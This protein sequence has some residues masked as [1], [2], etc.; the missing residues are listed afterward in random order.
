MIS[1]LFVF[2]LFFA[3]YAFFSPLSLLNSDRAIP[4]RYSRS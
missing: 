4:R 1:A 2:L 3:F